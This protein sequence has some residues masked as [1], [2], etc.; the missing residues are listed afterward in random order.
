[1]DILR[2]RANT[3]Q[4]VVLVLHEIT[5]AARFCDRLVLLDR[6]RVVAA[7]TPVEV[8]TDENLHATYRVSALRGAHGAS[9]YVL[10]WQRLD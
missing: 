1:M 3:G 7:G 6:G 8:L 2:A 5:L 10:P 9:Q 4:T